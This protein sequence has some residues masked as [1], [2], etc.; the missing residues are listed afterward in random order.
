[1]R[2]VWLGLLLSALGC[3]LGG[4]PAVSAVHG[5]LGADSVSLRGTIERI[6]FQNINKAAGHFTYNVELV[7]AHEGIAVSPYAEDRVPGR[8]RVR[9]HKIYWS[10]LDPQ[11]QTRI[12][13]G[14]PR[15]EMDVP[16]WQ[17]WVQGDS[18]ELEVVGYGAGLGFPAATPADSSARNVSSSV[19]SP[20]RPFA[21]R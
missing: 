10:Q 14:G 8:Y 6:H 5:E 21:A 11:E 3:R 1:M 17:G 12:A 4:P 13:P 9:V 15:H 19:R 16:Q 7:V 20:S 2:S 18:I